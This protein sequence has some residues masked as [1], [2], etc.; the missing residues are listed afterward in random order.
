MPVNKLKM[1]VSSSLRAFSF[2]KSAKYL[3]LSRKS[4]QRIAD[5]YQKQFITRRTT[6][7]AF[8]RSTAKFRTDYSKEFYRDLT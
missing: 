1:F 7:L 5:Y 2:L 8:E 6:Q 4:L 3:I